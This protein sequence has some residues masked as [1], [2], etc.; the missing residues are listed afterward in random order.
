MNTLRGA[1]CTVGD[2][3]G[4]GQGEAEC[5]DHGPVDADLD[6]DKEQSEEGGNNECD[7]ECDF[8]SSHPLLIL[9]DCETT[10]FSVYSDHITDIAAKV[11]AS[12]VPLQQPTFST[13]VR[14][15]KHISTV[16]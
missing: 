16:G 7:E 8:E 3:A 2:Y 12:P 15:S 13:L 6:V 9:F 11:I 5:G 10:G 4:D 14:T 1:G